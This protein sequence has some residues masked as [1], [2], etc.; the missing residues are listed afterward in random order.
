MRSVL[1][2]VGGILKP[3]CY[4]YSGHKFRAIGSLALAALALQMCASSATAADTSIIVE[5]GNFKP[6]YNVTTDTPASRKDTSQLEKDIQAVMEND[7]L[8]RSEKEDKINKLVS[9]SMAGE[10]GTC[11]Q[12]LDDVLVGLDA[13]S[14]ATDVIGII[15]EGIGAAVDSV[16]E[17]PG[18]VIQGVGAGLHLGSVI[19]TDVQNSLPNCNAQFTGTVETWANFA[20]AQGI[21]AFGDKLTL[22]NPDGVSYA[23][24]ITLGGGS[25]SGA[26]EG[27]LAT[28]DNADA[29]AIG[30]GASA[31]NANAS[32]FGTGASATRSATTAR[33]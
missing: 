7:K 26:G 31:S 16:G 12:Q 13:A 1:I 2:S 6:N 29:I 20:A 3:S 32:A 9:N 14:V 11:A 25:L 27:D 4:H 8:T 28:T 18:I 21:S 30:N 33:C 19:T 22:G 23:P 15:V 10:L 24:G 17:I 5:P